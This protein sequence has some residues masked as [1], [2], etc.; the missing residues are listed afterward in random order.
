MVIRKK[1]KRRAKGKRGKR[2]EKEKM[3]AKGIDDNKQLKYDWD[4]YFSFWLCSIC[5][6]PCVFRNAVMPCHGFA[7]AMLDQVLVYWRLPRVRFQMSDYWDAFIFTG[8]GSPSQFNPEVW[9]LLN[10]RFRRSPPPTA[11]QLK[12]GDCGAYSLNLYDLELLYEYHLHEFN[13]TEKMAPKTHCD[14]FSCQVAS[15]VKIH[16]L[17]P[18]VYRP[19]IHDGHLVLVSA[20]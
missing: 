6:L 15:P 16:Q 10:G 9:Q 19:D 18:H 11:W 17:L 5:W 8:S 14:D 12:Y 7:S 1:K 20:L 4:W 3:C 13:Y 2:K